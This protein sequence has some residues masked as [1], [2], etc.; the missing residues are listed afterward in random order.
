[1]KD[2]PVPIPSDS[3]VQPNAAIE[4]PMKPVTPV[5]SVE[6]VKI[7]KSVEDAIQAGIYP[8]RIAKGSS[9]SY[10]CRNSEGTIGNYVCFLTLF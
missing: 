9:G 8:I 7:F 10:F 5:S 3:L 2:H 4:N 1:L 6:F